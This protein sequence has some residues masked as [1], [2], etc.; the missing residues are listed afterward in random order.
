[1]STGSNLLIAFYVF[2]LHFLHMGLYDD[3]VALTKVGEAFVKSRIQGNRKG[4]PDEPSYLHS[5]R[6]RDLVSKQHHWDDPDYDLFLAA[7]L[8]DVIEDGGVTYAELRALG[9]S[10]RTIELVDLC[11]HRLDV[12]DSAERWV[13]MMARLVEAG[14]QD[15]WRIK[16]AD[17]IDNL[18]QSHA[19]PVANRQFMREVKAPLLLR[20]TQD[21]PLTR[22][23][24]A[25][26][27]A[28]K[29]GV[30]VLKDELEIWQGR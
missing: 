13:L 15:A 23:I 5:F 17:M 8:H 18:R 22:L 7:L 2:S 27:P 28:I 12:E 29:N 26:Y 24:C 25:E 14:D 16:L 30:D 1:M 4:L 21:Q 20:L 19:L 6:V 11:T 3:Y 10:D 9:F